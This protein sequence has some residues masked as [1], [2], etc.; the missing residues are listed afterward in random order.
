MKDGD[1]HLQVNLDA[2]TYARLKATAAKNERNISGE[3][4]IAVRDHL[5]RE[6]G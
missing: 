1:A 2:A 3:V 5:E 6:E 4:R